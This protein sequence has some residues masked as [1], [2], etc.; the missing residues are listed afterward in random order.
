V[1]AQTQIPDSTQIRRVTEEP[2]ASVDTAPSTTHLRFG[3]YD[4]NLLTGV[5]RK[6]G[7]KVRLPYQ[8]FRILAL[9]LRKPGQIVSRDELRQELWPGDVFVDFER[10][11]NSAMQRLRSALRD[12]SRKPRY[13][14]TF[15]KQGYRFVSEVEPADIIASQTRPSLATARESPLNLSAPDTNGSRAGRFGPTSQWIYVAAALVL[16]TCLTGYGWRRFVGRRGGGAETLPAAAIR[17]GTARKS[18]AVLGFRNIS[19]LARASWL[20]TAL[21]EMLTTEMSGGDHFRTIAEEQVGRAKLELSLPDRDSYA[22]DTLEKIHAY[23]GCDYVVDGSYLSLEHSGS[24]RL[25]LDARVQNVMTGETVANVAVV[26][27]QSDLFNLAFQAGEELR[28]KLGLEPLTPP[29]SDGIRAAL[30]ADMEAARLY[31]QGLSKLRALDNVAASHLLAKAVQLQPEYAPAYSALATAWSA[32]G[33]KARA[34]SAAQK[35]MNLRGSL[36]LAL[37]MEAEARYREMTGGWSQSIEIYKQLQHFYPDNVD[38]GLHI[39]KGLNSMGNHVEAEK[40][41]VALRDLP[42]AEHD[43]PRIDLAEAVTV[44]VL[45]DYARERVLA[46]TAARKAETVGARLLLARAKEVEGWAFDDLGEL[47]EAKLSYVVAQRMFTESGD[48]DE[49]ALVSMNTGLVLVKQGNLTEAKNKIEHA[50][51]VFRKRGDQARLGAALVNLAE[52]VYKNQGEFPKAEHLFREALAIFRDIG[53]I[54]ALPEVTYDIAEAEERQGK[55]REANDRLQGLLQQLR[56]SGKK[57]LLASALDSLGSIAEARG[58]M[59]TALQCHRQAVALFREMG[60]KEQYASAERHLGRALLLHGDAEGARHALDEA[61][62]IDHRINAKADTALDQLTIARVSLEQ[63]RSLNLKILEG[64]LEE[65]R[66][67][68]IGDDAIE[69]EVIV[70]RQLLEQGEIAAAAAVL[71]RVLPLSAKSYDPTVRFDAALAAA[72]LY[73]SQRRFEDSGRI[74]RRAL[75]QTLKADCV[76]C[77][78][79]ARLQLGAIGVQAG[80]MGQRNL[81]LRKLADEAQRRGFGLIAQRAG[82]AIR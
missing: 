45:G 3:L 10:G 72:R 49:S 26:G 75:P 20:S 51:S 69:G 14:E 8:S 60:D 1:S 64:A 68:K 39:A 30:P 41:I 11:L 17:P 4:V 37:R 33:Y 38:Y 19:G 36:P 80:V 13:I 57:G 79:E 47:E 67:Q 6:D 5:L 34:Q 32:L 16:V 76:R 15:P 44:G 12:T 74:L 50:V 63:R 2:A 29:D 48:V 71:R 53:E 52:G 35:A 25:R 22:N 70:A 58:D 78:L 9:L 62:T 21:S 43:D 56:R 40:N 27:S 82:E 23:L 31:S 54:E 61:L 42:S 7:L 24:G 55:F 77:Q 73:A 28:A 18:I 65:L 46:E 66:L 81:R 59:Q